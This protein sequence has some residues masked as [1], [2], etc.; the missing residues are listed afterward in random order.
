MGSPGHECWAYSP[1]G[2]WS[3][4]ERLWAGCKPVCRCD[5]DVANQA[6]K[7]A[8]NVN[9]GSVGRFC[10]TRASQ[11][12]NIPMRAIAARRDH[13]LDSRDSRND[14]PVSR[15]LFSRRTVQ[16]QLPQAQASSRSDHHG[17]QSRAARRHRARESQLPA[18]TF[19][20]ELSLG[21]CLGCCASAVRTLHRANVSHNFL[22]EF[23]AKVH[24]LVAYW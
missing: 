11:I 15:S 21:V 14:S 4:S 6:P 2:H 1:D 8:N 9:F 24:T 7:T 10:V 12:F 22:P 20:L 3:Q 17:H 16:S 13:T 23:S 18:T 19:T 5:R